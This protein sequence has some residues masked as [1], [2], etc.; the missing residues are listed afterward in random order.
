[1][2]RQTNGDK[3]A[4]CHRAVSVNDDLTLDFDDR[5]R[6][7]PGHY[8]FLIDDGTFDA[9]IA[10]AQRDHIIHAAMLA[11]QDDRPQ[12]AITTPPPGLDALSLS[13]SGGHAR[14]S[15]NLDSLTPGSRM[16][17]AVTGEGVRSRRHT[18]ARRRTA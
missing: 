15:A 1:M 16:G 2:C 5:H 8:A 11:P 17:R 18:P 14:M 6:P 9:V 12:A 4:R 13:D 10:G 3:D 7:Q